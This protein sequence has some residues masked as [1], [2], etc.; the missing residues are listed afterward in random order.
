M[1]FSRTDDPISDF[2]AYDRQQQ[3]QLDRL[4]RCCECDEPIQTEI[5]ISFEDEIICV[6]CLKDNHIKK[7][8]D[9]IE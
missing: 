9:L 3:A 4:P 6:Q 5:C 1:C 2:N 8:E 7:V